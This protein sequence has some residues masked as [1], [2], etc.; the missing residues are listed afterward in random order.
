MDIRNQ[1]FQEL[2][3]P[4]RWLDADK[5]ARAYEYALSF[6]SSKRYGLNEETV[7]AIERLEISSYAVANQWVKARLPATGTVHIVYSEAQVCLLDSSEF[8]ARW[9][10]IFVPRR[11]DA[12]VF[13]NLEPCVLFYCHEEE[14][15]FGWL[16]ST[17]P[18]KSFKPNPLRGSA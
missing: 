12:L 13:H 15:E 2:G 9:Q 7:S 11:D 16:S 6:S 14:L 8:L 3:M 17:P 4:V 5:A 10:D 1:E 18:N